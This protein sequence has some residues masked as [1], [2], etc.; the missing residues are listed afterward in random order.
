M[1]NTLFAL[2][3]PKNESPVED[4]NITTTMLYMSEAELKEFKF[5]CKEGMK[6]MLPDTYR[7][8]AN[9]TD[10]ILKLLREYNG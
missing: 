6:K 4:V 7:E 8:K 3:I 1:T 2:D 9:M 5:L 10:L